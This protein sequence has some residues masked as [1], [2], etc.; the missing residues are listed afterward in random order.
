MVATDIFHK[1]IGYYE[2]K[3]RM[4]SKVNDF[5]Q[6]IR[7]CPADIIPVQ[8]SNCTVMDRRSSNFRNSHKP[9]C[10]EPNFKGMTVLKGV[11]DGGFN[12]ENIRI[13]LYPPCA[14]PFHC[15]CGRKDFKIVVLQ[16]D[17]YHFPI[18]RFMCECGRE[19]PIIVFA[20][21]VELAAPWISAKTAGREYDLRPDAKSMYGSAISCSCR[22]HYFSVVYER[23]GF[24]FFPIE[25]PTMILV[26]R[27]CGKWKKIIL[28]AEI[29]A[30]LPW[31]SRETS[32]R[33]HEMVVRA[34]PNLCPDS[35]VSGDEEVVIVV[36]L[37]ENE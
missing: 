15:V 25:G 17:R 8:C 1:S 21:E 3:R 13:A 19:K 23:K 30:S 36:A 31:L 22:R 37:E 12:H 32:G 16:K 10:A 34:D 33:E 20:K 11:N 5:F 14:P 24:S 6:G 28:H 2:R 7:N 27:A 35:R 18:I 29:D 9:R 26:C 4:D